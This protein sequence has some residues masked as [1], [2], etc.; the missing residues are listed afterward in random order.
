MRRLA[1]LLE[2]SIERFVGLLDNRPQ[3]GTRVGL[4]P[5]KRDLIGGERLA[6]RIG[7]EAI[8]AARN[9]SNVKPYG[10]S[11]V[12]T[13]PHPRIRHLGREP[14]QIFLDLQQR[15]S[16]RH[17]I[18]VKPWNRSALPDFGWWWHRVI[19]AAAWLSAT[20]PLAILVAVLGAPP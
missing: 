19:A 20:Q 15:V 13:Q 7:E 17:H 16:D 11:A 3:R 9:V 12:H 5:R 2:S 10:R 1:N 8:G 6:T 14:L 18:W 4:R